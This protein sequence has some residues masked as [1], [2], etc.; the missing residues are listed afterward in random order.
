MLNFKTQPYKS[1]VSL[2]NV[3][4]QVVR[5]ETMDNIRPDTTR[6]PVNYLETRVGPDLHTVHLRAAN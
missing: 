4:R 2:V 1:P 5:C 6:R 3:R